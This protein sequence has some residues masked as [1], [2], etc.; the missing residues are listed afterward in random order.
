[1]PGSGA[2]L[3][4]LIGPTEPSPAPYEV[5]DALIDLEVTSGEQELDGFRMNFSLGREK[6]A[7]YELLKRGR[8]EPPNR[9]IVVISIGTRREVLIDGLITQHQVIP[10]NQAGGS[11]LHVDGVDISIK[12]NLNPAHKLYPSQSDSAIVKSLL[13][14]YR[15]LGLEANVEKSD[16]TPSDND[17][18]PSQQRTDLDY[19]RY[20]AQRNS[21]VFYV[22]PTTVP[23]RCIAYWG[24]QKRQ[25]EAQPPLTMNMG[26]YT[27]VDVPINFRYDALGPAEPEMFTLDPASRHIIPVEP[28]SS[29]YPQLSQRVARP[30]RSTLARDTARLNTALARQRGLSSMQESSDAVTGTGEVDA[31]RYGRILRAHHIVGVRGVGNSFDGEYYVES[32]THRIKR[33]EY[34]QSFTLKREGRGSTKQQLR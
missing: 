25:G 7:D 18:R 23:R 27:N 3:Q 15:D 29:L 12:L 24:P 10:S 1:M 16:V 6:G 13:E 17:R 20:L 19:I 2:R 32:V 8:L 30:L 11:R 28:S 14:A 21:F 33:G 5:V 34:K 31:V 9:V 4:L 26:S 22:E